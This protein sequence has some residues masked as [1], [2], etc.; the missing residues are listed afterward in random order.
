MLFQTVCC[1]AYYTVNS[2]VGST[3]HNALVG[4]LVGCT[5]DSTVRLG[6]I[7]DFIA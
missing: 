3:F 5:V 7:V 4:T 2:T 6:L 1:I